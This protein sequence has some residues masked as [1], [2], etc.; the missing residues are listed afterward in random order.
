MIRI[1]LLVFI[2]LPIFSAEYFIDFAN[3]KDKNSG[4]SP[5]QAW[6]HCPG[7]QQAAEN[8]KTCKLSPGDI[9]RFK[10]G[11]R[12]YGSI[13]VK[14]NG[15]KD[16]PIIFDG[17]LDDSYGAGPAIIDGALPIDAWKQCGSSEEA[18]GNKHWQHI[19]YVDVESTASWKLINLH[20][21]NTAY[22]IAQDPNMPDPH[23]QE[24]A[25]HFH[26]SE[27]KIYEERSLDIKPIG[28]KV[29]PTRPLVA[30]FDESR[31][32]AVINDINKGAVS[33]T[34]PEVKTFHSFGLAPQP[35]YTNPSKVRITIDGKDIITI[36]P[37]AAE[38]Q[39]TEQMFK[40]DK[41]VTGKVITFYFEGA[42]KDA[43]GKANSWGAIRKISGY[44]ESGNNHLIT[45]RQ[46][47]FKH[48]YF[49]QSDPNYWDGATL[50]VYGSPAAV[51]YHTIQG[52]N[53]EKKEIAISLFTAKQYEKG[54]SFSILNTLKVLD[55]PGEYVV[56]KMDDKKKRIYFWP[57]DGLENLRISRHND[58]IHVAASHI[59]VRGIHT[60]GQGGKKSG[61]GINVYKRD[62]E[63]VSIQHCDIALCRG[64]APAIAMTG[65]SNSLI[66][67]S[68][69]HN[70]TLHTKGLVARLLQNIVVRNCTFER[71]TSTAFDYYTVTNGAVVDC[72]VRDNQGMHA[73]GL[74]F[75]VGCQN[76]IVEGNEVYDGNAG[77][78]FQDGNN[79]IIRNNIIESKHSTGIGIWAGK[80]YNNIVICNNIIRGNR[81]SGSAKNAIYGGNPG[82]KGLAIYNNIIDGGFDGNTLHKADFNHN[83]FLDLGSTTKK[84]LVNKNMHIAD[85]N[86]LFVDAAKRDYRYKADSPAIGQGIALGTI[87]K[88]DK[89]GE[90]WNGAIN[91][92]PYQ[93]NSKRAYKQN[94]EVDIFTPGDYQFNEPSIKGKD[95]SKPS[96]PHAQEEATA[97]V[98][99][100]AFSGQGNGK[101]RIKEAAQS[102]FGWD[103][104]GHWLEWTISV[105][106]AGLYEICLNQTTATISKRSFHING[107]RLTTLTDVDMTYTGGW[108]N[109]KDHYLPQP[110]PLKAGD[111]IL[112]ITGAGGSLNVMNIRAYKIKE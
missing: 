89:N 91:I 75:Y 33:V 14:T 26:K 32:S 48:S 25:T 83:I 39:A 21:L 105:K 57:Q 47:F 62:G 81:K 52:F 31:L 56:K 5:E 19:Y 13:S 65:T 85:I 34:L 11:V 98:K 20:N 102:I 109:W 17:N 55:K 78:T 28:M 94:R 70:N 88:T 100:A 10:G 29:N 106:Q 69:I 63:N 7:D 104:Q 54:G 15:S 27:A 59:V 40:L 86:A 84:D 2:T 44:D 3:G 110:I 99:G 51:Y 35:R 38:K 112:R 8:A 22:P 87:N 101:V 36:E 95:Y 103:D 60:R 66:E 96:F 9:I 23:Y 58:G 68:K 67:H 24:M 30:L 111:N 108:R 1:A 97:I 41:P 45:S 42:H 4:T 43:K 107:Q 6:Q 76:I 16:A 12:Y 61:V 93:V 50:S 46:S 18:G 80:V 90:A 72:L 64:Y 92:G 71:N 73:N 74:T 79:I 53:P 37:Q 77:I 82:T 49:N